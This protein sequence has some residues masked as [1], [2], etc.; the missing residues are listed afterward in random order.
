MFTIERLKELAKEFSKEVLNDHRDDWYVSEQAA[1]ACY[2]DQ[3]LEWLET[4]V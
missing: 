4:K 2:N 3:F 1:F